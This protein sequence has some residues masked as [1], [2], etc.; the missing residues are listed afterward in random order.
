VKDA[1]LKDAITAVL[2]E[3]GPAPERLVT[4]HAL[5]EGRPRPPALEP[6]GG[7]HRAAPR[8]E[9]ASPVPAKGP[10][11]ASPGAPAPALDPVD[12]LG[13]VE[14]D[15]LLLSELVRA[16]LH[17]APMQMQAIDAALDRGEGSAIVRAANTLRGSIGTFGAAPAVQV[18]GRLEV[19]GG[20]GDL[21]AARK[22]R[23]DLEREMARLVRALTPFA[24]DTERD[25]CAS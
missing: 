23:E 1:D 22:V 24:Y 21:P 16:F 13:R 5:H 25:E 14:G 18:L 6:E 8:A 11:P 10:R 20:L 2:G 4:R 7:S 12:L 17:T 9:E 19:L 3:P 15:R